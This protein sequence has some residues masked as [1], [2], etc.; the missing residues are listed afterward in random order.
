MLVLWAS[1]AAERREKSD[2]RSEPVRTAVGA[3]IAFIR[4]DT[5]VESMPIDP[6]RRR[7]LTMAGVGIAAMA[8]CTG[9]DSDV[10][11]SDG[12][13]VIDSEDYAPRDPDVQSESDLKG[14]AP[15]TAATPTPTKT[16]TP[17]PTTTT[18]PTTSTPAAV[19]GSVSVPTGAF[20]RRTHV[21]S[22]SDTEV[23]AVVRSFPE[24]D[25]ENPKLVVATLEYPRGEVVA[26][27]SGDR[28]QVPGEGEQTRLT[29]ELT[30]GE[31]PRDTRVNH[32]LFAMPA[33][34]SLED[35]SADDL[36]LLF[37]TD[38]FRIV[39]GTVR[40]DRP[41]YELADAET[42]SFSRTN[43]EG[44]YAFRY[45]G[46]TDGRSWRV[47]FI[48]WKSAYAESR[49]LPRGRSYDEYV[50]LARNNGIAGELAT[51]LNEQAEE[52]GFT[53]KRMKAE[54]LIDFVQSLPY[55]ADD[56]STGF[57][58]YTKTV[59]ETITEAEGDC[60]DTAIL[61]AAVMQAE[62]FGYDTVLIAPPEHMAAGVYGNDLPGYYW[63]Y[64]GRDYY[65]IETTGEGWGVG[66]LPDVYQ[67]T[68]A[69]V[70]Q[71]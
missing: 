48:I 62:P 7:V 67:D 54:L 64:D 42:G 56:V 38:P 39:D 4:A 18:I 55:A 5:N 27:G 52:N 66:D 45:S 68:K 34:L 32:Q 17:R 33:D 15:S 40:R 21:R 44:L 9:D 14:A 51:L 60:E 41:T 26:Y 36:D 65:Y 35:A 2:P 25:V 59:E 50:S 47:S 8:G 61:L 63:T 3:A 53:N 30:R 23:E 58:Q 57:D 69:T 22:Y 19:E 46:S 20:P 13:G 37:E 10:Q 71:V 11:D 24:V 29:V 70:Y 1:L 49:E 43:E 16:P 6:E 28:F 31:V 12:D